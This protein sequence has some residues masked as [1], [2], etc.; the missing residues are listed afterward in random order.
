MSMKLQSVS[1]I[2]EW[3]VCMS[4]MAIGV[5]I[6]GVIMATCASLE[7]LLK[8]DLLHICIMAEVF[9]SYTDRSM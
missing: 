6:L 4:F 8:M 7:V 9:I 2:G 5:A 1:G 3:R